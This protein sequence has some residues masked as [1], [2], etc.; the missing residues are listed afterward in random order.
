[1][2]DGYWVIIQIKCILVYINK[3]YLIG[4]KNGARPSYPTIV[5]LPSQHSRYKIQEM[6]AQ[7]M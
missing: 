7:N 3:D 1:M 5:L 4:D 2:Y 6:L